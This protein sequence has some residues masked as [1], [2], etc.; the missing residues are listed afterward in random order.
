MA[1]TSEGVSLPSPTPGPKLTT[2]RLSLEP[3]GHADVDELHDL[4]TDACVRRYLL[5]DEVVPRE[6]VEGEIQASIERFG[7][8]GMGLWTLRLTGV[9]G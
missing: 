3:F 1:S 7:A 4:F 6:W 8:G 2:E 9:A 5:D